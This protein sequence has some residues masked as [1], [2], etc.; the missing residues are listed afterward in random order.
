VTSLRKVTGGSSAGEVAT[1]AVWAANR[2]NAVI[3]NVTYLRCIKDLSTS[4][5]LQFSC[6]GKLFHLR[7]SR[8]ERGRKFVIV[9]AP[10]C[11]QH[12]SASSEE[13][14]Q[15]LRTGVREGPTQ[16]EFVMTSG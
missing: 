1:A 6:W 12:Y 7:C 4:P 13:R 15:L 3:A 9:A 5:T 11:N 16:R 14:F 8:S 2:H 10:A